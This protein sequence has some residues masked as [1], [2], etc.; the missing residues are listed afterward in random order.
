M[1][2]F[3]FLRL[4]LAISFAAPVGSS[5]SKRRYSASN[6]EPW[7][8][9]AQCSETGFQVCYGGRQPRDV[10]AGT[11][12]EWASLFGQN[13]GFC[14]GKDAGGGESGPDLTRSQLVCQDVK[15]DK[16]GDVVRNGRPEKGMPRFNLPEMDMAAVVA[17]IH[18]QKTKAES[19]KGG[20]KGVDVADLQTGN[21]EAGQEILR[22]ELCLLPLPDRRFGWHRIQSFKDSNSN[23]D[24]STREMPRVQRP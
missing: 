9:D 11:R 20:R 1:I 14:H 4:S 6:D 21:L 10:P 19:K 12:Q 18:D 15:G 24:F 23:S 22:R 7:C 16:I 3:S 13:C 17:F 5:W 2:S 8:T